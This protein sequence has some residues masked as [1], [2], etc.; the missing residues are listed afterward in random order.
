MTIFRELFS[1]ATGCIPFRYQERLAAA[2]STRTIVNV[3]T[4]A[5]KTAA[6]F[7][8]WLWRRRFAPE[9]IRARTPRRLVYCLPMRVLVEQIRDSIRGWLQN[10]DLTSKISLAVL[11]GGEDEEG[12]DLYPERDSIIVGTQDMLLSRALNRG[13][14]ASRARWPIQFG[15]LNNDCCWVMDEVQLMGPGLTTTAQLDAFRTQM[16]GATG[17]M[18]GIWMS[19]TV[20]RDWLET[21]D[22]DSSSA[23]CVELTNE[24]GLTDNDESGALAEIIRAAKPL[25][26]ARHTFDDAGALAMEIFEAHRLGSRTL[27]VVNTVGR[28]VELYQHL[29]RAKRKAAVDAQLVLVHSRFRPQERQKKIDALLTSP[30]TGGNIVVSTQ[31]VEAGVDVSARVLFTELAP[32]SSLVQRFGRCNRRGEYKDRDA[33]VFWI[34]NK[35]ADDSAA[36][37]YAAGDLELARKQLEA[38]RDAGISRLPEH[39]EMRLPPSDALRR[40]DL[41]D[42]FDTT[43][44]LAG[45]DV[46]IDRY[47]RGADESDVRVFWREWNLR[48]SQR[49]PANEPAPSREE[50]CPAPIGDFRA[51]VEDEDRRHMVW[52]WNFLGRLWERA[53]PGRIA[54]GQSFMVHRGAGGY[55]RDLGWIRASKTPIELPVNLRGT[56]IPPESNDD[57]PLSFIG[58]WQVVAEHCARSWN[59]S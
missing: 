14:A 26:K 8:F 29:E 48:E 5:G 6:A 33:A 16:C 42:L 35:A 24:K 9:D 40:R 50:I 38:C 56:T 57:D 32:W 45:N 30:G 12:W 10:L 43:P 2:E 46:D 13:Y 55:S 1:K 53:E 58:V 20:R 21:V 37:P 59:A 34:D 44:D 3:P 27:V 49:P 36:A 11:M 25:S 7:F 41:V 19:A 28:A 51:F 54:P 22:F 23:D 4:G 31:V 39:V 17:P 18:W 52:R 15:L 47:V